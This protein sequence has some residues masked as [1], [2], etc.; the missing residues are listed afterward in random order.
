MRPAGSCL[1]VGVVG[2]V[3]VVVGVGG[4]SGCRDGVLRARRKRRWRG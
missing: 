1:L 3:V 2:V 4:R